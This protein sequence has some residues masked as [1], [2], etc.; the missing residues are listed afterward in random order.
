M[1]TMKYIQ[2][3]HLLKKMKEK[4]APIFPI[5]DRIQ[6]NPELEQKWPHELLYVPIGATATWFHDNGFN[7]MIPQVYRD[8]ATVAALAGWRRAKNIY[9]MAPELTEAL[10]AQAK[11]D[12]LNLSVDHI[13]LP[14]WTM[15][16]R[17]Q[18]KTPLVDA[19]GVNMDGVFIH[20]EYD[21]G[22]YELRFLPIGENGQAYPTLSL[23]VPG[24]K[25]TNIK[26]CVEKSIAVYKADFTR[27]S[28]LTS[29]IGMSVETMYSLKKADFVNWIS[30]V[31]YISAVNAEIKPVNPPR[32]KKIPQN[33]RK[34]KDIPQEIEQYNVGDD[35]AVYLRTL[36]SQTKKRGETTRDDGTGDS[37][38]R[39]APRTHLRRAHWHSYRTGSRTIP[40]AARPTVHKWL[41]PVLVN[42]GPGNKS[43]GDALTVIQVK[44]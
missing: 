22:Q 27:H 20:W 6:Q 28:K 29:G 33:K 13:R 26:E 7:F 2:P 36:K 38:K 10:Y 41:P 18:V 17:P 32:S 9:N 23:S 40:L 16:I 43:D 5:L 8:L 35:V 4:Y 21:K 42:A 11:E 3:M 1:K 12:K 14:V 24:D 34:V 39:A 30:L 15:Y 25:E 19:R 44:E 37:G 31:L